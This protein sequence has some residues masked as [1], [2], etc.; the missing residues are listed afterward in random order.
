MGKMDAASIVPA[1]LRHG[2]LSDVLAARG[3]DQPAGRVVGIVGVRLDD[4]VVKVDGLL[5]G[6]ALV[7]EIANGVVGVGKLLQ[8]MRYR[9][10]C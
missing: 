4:C 5:R 3:H 7:G 8:D 2:Q 1:G 9:E 10:A 6:I